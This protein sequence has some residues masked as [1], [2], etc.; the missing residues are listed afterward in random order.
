MGTV[1]EGEGGT[2][3]KNRICCLTQCFVTWRNGM[4]QEV[5][6]DICISMADSC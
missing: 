2:N 6:G 5:E 1:G 3:G 4:G